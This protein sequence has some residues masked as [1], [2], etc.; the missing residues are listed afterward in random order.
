MKKFVISTILSLLVCGAM[1][2]GTP[3]GEAM[4]FVLVPHDPA[5]LSMGGTGFAGSAAAMTLSD[6]KV[7]A[8]GFFQM[9]SPSFA[10]EKFAGVSSF[11]KVGESLGFSIDGAYGICPSYDIFNEA[12]KANGSF[13]PK[14][15][16]VEIGASYRILPIL[17]AGVSF[18]YLSSSLSNSVSNSAIAIDAMA[19]VSLGSIKAG[20]GLRNLGGKVESKVGTEYGLPT[21]LFLGGEYVLAPEGGKSV[22]TVDADFDYFFSGSIGLAAGVRY[23]WN[24]MVSLMGGYHLGTEGA[25]LPSFASAGLGLCFGGVTINA[26]YLLASDTLGGSMSFGLGFRF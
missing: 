13:T 23:C 16:H 24:N 19:A 1:S 12:G 8:S 17:S 7:D 14:D 22:V 9:W 11:F 26:N 25:P 3:G 5:S 4:S 2:A 20:A 18:K 6:T 15:M 21:S 10:D